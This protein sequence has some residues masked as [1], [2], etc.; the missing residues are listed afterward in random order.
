MATPSTPL[1]STEQAEEVLRQLGE[2]GAA[3]EADASDAALVKRHLQGA[4]N[5]WYLRGKAT[6]PFEALPPEALKFLGV[7][8]AR[9]RPHFQ[10]TSP[11]EAAQE[12]RL[13]EMMFNQDNPLPEMTGDTWASY[14]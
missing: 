14:S 9:V 8:V 3:D 7:I 5:A 13:A 10:G 2:I 11:A 1:T 12:E 4:F 6:W